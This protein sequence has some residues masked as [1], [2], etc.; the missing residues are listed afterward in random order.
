MDSQR[1]VVRR[2]EPAERLDFDEQLWP[3]NLAL[4]LACG[5]VAGMIW[6]ICD[7][8]T[9]IWYESGY[10]WMTV[11]LASVLGLGGLA[12]YLGGKTARRLQMAAFLSL[13][14]HGVG[15]GALSLNHE[16]HQPDIGPKNIAKRELRAIDFL[17]DYH[18]TRLLPN[19]P[20]E[21]IEKPVETKIS[22]T[23]L[24]TLPVK[25]RE[26]AANLAPLRRAT[27]W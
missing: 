13:A 23:A 27:R 20:Q 10:F 17:P 5:C 22:D 14:L 24:P 8:Q 2:L 25:P 3:V 16:L 26:Q 11:L 18:L 9:P 12:V 21:E 4:M 6:A 1:H 15:I 19:R 7:F